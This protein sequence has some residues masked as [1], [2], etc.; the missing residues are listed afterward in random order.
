MHHGW[1]NHRAHKTETCESCHK[2]G[3]SVSASDLLLPNL[4]SCRTCHGGE[5]AAGK[6][7]SSCAMCHDYHMGTGKPSI[8]VQQRIGAKKRERNAAREEF[9]PDARPVAAGG[10]R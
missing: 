10:A 1:F 7:Q 5:S 9:R 3:A 4:A 6:V 8:L 2:A